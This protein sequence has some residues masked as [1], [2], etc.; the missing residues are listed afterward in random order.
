MTDD[1]TTGNSPG[2]MDDAQVRVRVPAKINLSLRVGPPRADGFHPLGTIFHAVNLFEDVTASPAPSG[3]VSLKMS[4]E[5][6]EGVPTDASNLAVKAA[7]ALRDAYGTPDLGVHL[8]IRKTIP[9]AGG[10]AGGSAD[11]AGALLACSV[12][13]DLDT[14]PDDLHELAAHLG[15]DVPFALH[16][17]TA[18]GSGRGEDLVPL[19]SRGTY[20]WVLAFAEGGLST[21]AVFRRFDEIGNFSETEISDDVM[22]ALAAG[23]PVALGRSLINDL[24][25]AAISLLPELQGTLDAGL[26]AGALGAIVSGSGPTCAFLAASRSDQLALATKLDALPNIRA[27]RR[28]S[29]PVPGARLLG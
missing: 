17:G 6:L 29:G 27:I 3:V 23:D 18:I 21:P 24:Q 9:V 22:N 15:S 2:G 26:A 1:T 14:T 25:P 8:A 20:E 13:W 12:F 4:G 11:C 5:S 10:M 7:L 19:L 28:A 16:G